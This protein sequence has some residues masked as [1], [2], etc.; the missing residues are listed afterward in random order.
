VN[1][2]LLAIIC[3]IAA[4]SVISIAHA[5]ITNID[6]TTVTTDNVVA[7]VVNSTSANIGTLNVSSCSGCGGGSGEGD[8]SSYTMISNSTATNLGGN[9]FYNLRISDTGN[10]L[11]EAPN[12]QICWLLNSTNYRVYDNS[13]PRN[14]NNWGAN[15]VNSYAV[16]SSITGKY[17]VILSYGTGSNTATYVQVFKDG[18]LLT[19]M[20]NIGFYDASSSYAPAVAI[21]PNGKYIIELGADVT[22]S[23][24]QITRW[25]G[26]P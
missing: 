15:D 25:Q 9:S 21:S 11:V 3:I 12:G 18:A 5:V 22:T 20:S 7:S 19:N 8:Y 13:G 4:G 10:V 6:D 16:G 1:K 2:Q 26:V 14:C 17:Q 23:T 24:D